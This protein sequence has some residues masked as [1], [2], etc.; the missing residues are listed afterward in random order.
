M[1]LLSFV[2]VIFYFPFFPSVFTAGNK[3][4]LAFS[5]KT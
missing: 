2:T 1:A 3:L 5:G 4:H